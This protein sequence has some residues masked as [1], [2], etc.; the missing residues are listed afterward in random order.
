MIAYNDLGFYVYNPHRPSLW[1]FGSVPDNVDAAFEQEDL[2]AN[3]TDVFPVAGRNNIGIM[4]MKPFAAGH[5]VA[6]KSTP[7]KDTKIRPSSD[8][9]ASETL[10]SI[11]SY[12]EVACVVPGMASVEEVEE[13]VLAVS[14]SISFSKKERSTYE[15]KLARVKSSLCSR[16][17]DCHSSC[18]Q[19]L[20]ISWL[21]RSSY[22]AQHPPAVEES[23]D[24]V[25]YFSLHQNIESVCASC[26]SVTCHCPYGIDIRS[27]L[28]DIHNFIT[29]LRNNG[30]LVK[31]S[32]R[33]ESRSPCG[34]FRAKLLKKIE[35]ETVK[36]ESSIGLR[37]H[38]ENSGELPWLVWN[39]SK[40]TDARIIVLHEESLLHTESLHRTVMP[41][42]R[43]FLTVLF[44]V[45]R[46]MESSLINI[47]LVV[48]DEAG[49]EIPVSICSFETNS[50]KSV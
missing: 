48:P 15:Q 19:N 4:I 26:P 9:T 18:S 50:A 22:I 21:F 2:L 5:L 33:I 38:L 6:S 11:L 42:E 44:S 46:N 7:P 12:S 23:W 35:L 37:I 36:N 40:K 30:L 25:E 14:A 3:R 16:C 28:M 10:R 47:K 1:S 17:G 49:K 41:L 27:S 8:I 34:R 29:E 13:N 24:D 32:E 45:P 20:P 31:P 39:Q 43:T